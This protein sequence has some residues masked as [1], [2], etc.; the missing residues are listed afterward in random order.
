MTSRL[1]QNIVHQMKDV[2]DRE[3]GVI[4]DTGLIVACSDTM[5]N[6]EQIEEIPDMIESTQDILVYNGFTFQ[7]VYDETK[8]E[9]MVFVAGEDEIA[10]KYASILAI[11]IDNIKQ[12][13]DEKYDKATFVK[14]VILDNILPGDISVKAKE[15]HLP[16]EAHRVVFFIR[17]FDGNDVYVHDTIQNLFPARNKDFVFVIDKHNIA[18]IKEVKSDL[19]HKELEQIAKTIVD[20]LATELLVKVYVGIGTVVNHIRD[21]AKSYKEARVALEVG[22]VFETE[23]Y[24]ISYDNLGIGRLIYQLPTT[25]CELFLAEVF[26][27]GSID[28][29]DEE[30]LQTIN[31]FFE[32]N[33]NVSET[34]RQLYVHRNTLVYRLDKIQKI[35]GLDLRVFDHAIIFKVAMMVKRYLDSNPIKI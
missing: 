7:P 23:N 28:D 25:L 19:E 27:K 18:L 9:Y 24:I 15:L 10:K 8:I 2:I 33:L 31:K 16:L 6:G 21:L 3:L 5:K 34:S 29:L 30:T 32:N 11:S 13:Y 35:T 14:N 1:F 12:Y 17:T 4:D 20:T 22:K 26:K